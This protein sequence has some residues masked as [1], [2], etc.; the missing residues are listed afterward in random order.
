MS[1]TKILLGQGC[2]VV[3]IVVGGLWSSTQW[4]ALMLVNQPELGAPLAKVLG[5]PI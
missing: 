1:P 5:Q 2:L 4:A 3:S